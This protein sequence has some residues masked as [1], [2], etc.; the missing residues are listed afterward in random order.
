MISCTPKGN[1]VCNSFYH[2]NVFSEH[3]P[4]IL[5]MNVK[6]FTHKCEIFYSL[7]KRMPLTLSK[8][9]KNKT[10]GLN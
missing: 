9:N 7:S 2:L 5:C 6:L 3:F 1:F 10:K 4:K 8:K